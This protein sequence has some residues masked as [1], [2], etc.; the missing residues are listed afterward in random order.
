MY[1]LKPIRNTLTSALLKGIADVFS[2]YIYSIIKRVTA[3]RNKKLALRAIVTMQFP[4]FTL[5][6]YIIILEIYKG[7]VE[8]F[9]KDL[10]RIDIILV[11]GIWHFLLGKGIKLIFNISNPEITLKSVRDKVIIYIIGP[12]IYKVITAS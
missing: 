3:L 11:I 10:F 4:S 6:D 12:K 8:R 2:E 9:V 7:E 1:I 5:H